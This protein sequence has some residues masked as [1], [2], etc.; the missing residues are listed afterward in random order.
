VIDN[1]QIDIEALSK[2]EDGIEMN[3]LV[4][5]GQPV[6]AG[7]RFPVHNIIQYYRVYDGDVNQILDDF[8]HLSLEQVSAAL[9]YYDRHRDAIDAIVLRNREAYERGLAARRA[10]SD[11]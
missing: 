2:Y 7:T 6:I 11:R 5:A 1:E 10:R 4:C 9:S 3:P 8:P